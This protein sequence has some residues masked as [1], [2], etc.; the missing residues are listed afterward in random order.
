LTKTLIPK[1]S[2][3]ELEICIST[4]NKL[5]IDSVRTPRLL[6]V[7]AD[8]AGKADFVDLAFHLVEQSYV[9]RIVIDEVHVVESEGSEFRFS[10]LAI[11]DLSMCRCQK[12][13]L[14][15]TVPPSMEADLF[16]KLKFENVS[17]DCKVSR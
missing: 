1:F 7:S 16:A 4:R 2:Q 12:V 10:L 11:G 14:S 6:V 15:A 17:E 5:I 13:V 3:G 8:I 9:N